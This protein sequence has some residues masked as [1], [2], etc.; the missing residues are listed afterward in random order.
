MRRSYRIA[1]AAVS[2]VLLWAAAAPAAHI[3]AELKKLL[4]EKG[5]SEVLPVLMVFPEQ[6]EMDELEVQLDDATPSKRR[7]SAIAALKRKARKAQS[8]AWEILDDPD[9]PGE[10]AYADMLYFANAIAF[11]AD[12]E[13][14]LAVAEAGDHEKGAEQAILFHD[15]EYDLLETRAGGAGEDLKIAREDTTWNVRWV[16][17]P[18]V[19]SELGHTGEG[20]LVGHIDTGVDLAHPD[21]RSRLWTNGAEVLGNGLD[22]DGNGFVDDVRGWD[23]GDGDAD[24]SD[25]SASAGHGTHTAGTVVGDGH[26]GVQTGVAPGAWLLPVKIFTTAG[27]SSLGRIWAAQQYCIERGCR[28]ITMSLGVKGDVPAPYVRNDRFNAEAIR[29]AG[30]VLVNSA[31]N[32]HHAFDP[33][34]ELGMTARIPA[35]WSVLDVPR[36][37][38][39]GVITVGATGQRAET[40]YEQSSRGPAAWDQ[41]DPWHDWPYLPGPGLIK[42]DVVAPGEGIRSTQPAPLMYS[43]ETWSGTSMACPLVAGVAALM[44]EKNPTLSPAG[45]DSLLE[46]TALDLGA[47]GKDTTFGAGLVDA[48]AAV[49]AV[50]SDL[51][52]NLASAAFEPDPAGGGVLDPGEVAAAVFALDN[53]G[54]V[55]ATGVTGRLAVAENPF[56]S[57]GDNTAAFA[58]I[59]AGAAGRNTLDPFTLA[60][61]PH[62]PHGHEFTMT[63]TVITAEGFERVFDLTGQVGLPEYR[64]H[65]IGDVYCTVTARGS[66][67]YLH[68]DQEQGWGMGLAGG[69][70]ALFLSS[71]WAGGGPDYVCNNDLTASGAD[72]AEWV[73]RVDPTGNV[74]VLAQ[75]AGQ[76]AFHTVFTDG[77]HDQPRDITVSLTSRSWADP[78]LSRVIKLDYL[79]TNAG[80]RYFAAYHAGLFVDWDVVDALGNVGGT[81]P[82]TRAAWVG[83][84]GGPV[85]GVAAVGDAP[86]SNVTVIDNVEYV[87]P[88]SHV[89]NHHKYQFLR[90]TITTPEIDEPS[91]LSTL[92]AVGPLD[93][94]PGAQVRVTLLVARGGTVGEFLANVRAAGAASGAVTAAPAA[95][96][97]HARLALAQNS[98]NPFNPRTEIAFSLP[99]RG[100]VTLTVFD[101]AGRRVRMLVRDELESGRHRV[102]WDGRDDGGAPVSS[103]TYLYRL[104]TPEGSLARKMLLVQ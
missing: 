75:T 88:V 46:L 19:W 80:D 87:Y 17:A 32:D 64:T 63:L 93:L 26:A 22:D 28:I 76:Q 15:K 20:V 31:G 101:L 83:M 103:G 95:R 25:D 29:A 104:T 44:L 70:S 52:P 53:A 6:A 21:L 97:P 92:V 73:P 59:A 40:I 30:V 86:V 100:L 67:G 37:S 51:L 61:S 96:A 36:S 3:D 94:D 9:L 77:G 78:E 85:Y 33:P 57:V 50:P 35:P 2:L 42:P 54:L 38:L 24:P 74:K 10:L 34:I 18:E 90:G 7:R 58:D 84:P 13:V 11:G 102:R 5:R 48:Y 99:A 65:D 43:G 68:D 41:I 23:F 39:G 69:A 16:R 12:R 66:L 56:V 1:I 27:T 82:G 45:I 79:I 4:A 8:D 60:V 98:P 14:I 71:L 91:D 55:D 72:P 47:P 81:D 89:T 62:A 49:A